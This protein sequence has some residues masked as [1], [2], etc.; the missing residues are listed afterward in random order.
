LDLPDVDAIILV[1]TDGYTQAEASYQMAKVIEVFKKN[2]ATHIQ[3]TDS[4]E[5]AEELWLARKSV[6]IAAAQL[7]PN[8]VSEDVTVPMSKIPDLLMGI[9]AIVKNYRLPFIIFGHAGDGNLHPKIMYDRSDPEQAE[10]IEHA[11]DEIF[12]LACDLGGTLTGEHGIGLAKAPYMGLE[13][14]Q[15]AMD[16]MRSLKRLFD[17]NNILNP[18]KMNL[19]S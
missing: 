12:K 10:G 1:E 7:R 18:G 19:D 14:D 6:G 2:R 3:K 16:L 4:A 15:V 13:H 5:E 11:V 17:P 9:S 8:F